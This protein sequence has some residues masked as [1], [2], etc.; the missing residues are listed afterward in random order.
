MRQFIDIITENQATDYLRGVFY[1]GTAVE[2]ND[3]FNH[4]AYF[5]QNQN[6][7]TEYALM[8]S[9]VD[10]DPPVLY[11]VRLHCTNP[12]LLDTTMMQ[13][14][15]QTREGHVKAAELIAQGHD[16]V[17][18]DMEGHDEVCVLDPSKIEILEIIKLPYR[19]GSWPE[20]APTQAR[21]S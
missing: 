21:S 1:H 17:L 14:L 19:D 7:A 2:K 6:E 20:A 16:V 9:E 15:A 11:A 4:T 8:D 13:D 18:S 10:G 3:G 12:A 5:T